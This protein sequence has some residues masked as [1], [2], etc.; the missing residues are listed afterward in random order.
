MQVEHAFDEL[1]RTAFEIASIIGIYEARQRDPAT[2]RKRAQ[3]LLLAG[4]QGPVHRLKLVILIFAHA[5][6][7]GRC[8]R[9]P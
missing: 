8:C 3:L 1:R 2:G 7:P 6:D 5:C 9:T 4:G